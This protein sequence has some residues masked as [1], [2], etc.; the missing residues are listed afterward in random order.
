MKIGGNL[1]YM[2]SIL[3]ALFSLEQFRNEVV[4]ST[5]TSNIIQTLQNLFT[6]LL[7]SSNSGPLSPLKMLLASKPRAFNVREKRA[8]RLLRISLVRIFIPILK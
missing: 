4:Q 6:Q 8:S 5:N 1:C 3:Q 2:N 7:D